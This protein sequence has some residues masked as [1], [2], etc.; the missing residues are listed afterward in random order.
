[1]TI[2]RTNQYH[3]INI[4]QNKLLFSSIT[5]LLINTNE[6]NSSLIFLSI[7]NNQI[8]NKTEIGIKNCYVNKII[9]KRST[10]EQYRSGK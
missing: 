6:Q 2:I 9:N 5:K 4:K 1:M 8:I 7:L 3:I 10:K